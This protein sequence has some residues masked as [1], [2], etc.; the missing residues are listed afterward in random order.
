[1]KKLT[2]KNFILKAQ[3]VHS[4]KYNYDF[5]I[6]GHAKLKVK[7][8]CPQHGIFKMTPNNHLYGKQGCPLCGDE[9]TRT[10]L[11][12]FIQRC[13]QK[14]NNKYN[15]SNVK[16]LGGRKKVEIICP[17]HGIFSQ[18]PD[19]HMNTGTGCPK[20]TY[21][22]YVGGYS[23]E[24]FEVNNHFKSVSAILYLVKFHKDNENFY[25]IGITTQPLYKR[26]SG[27]DYDITPVATKPTTLFEA[28][29]LEQRLFDKL[30][31][32]KHTPSTK[33]KG[34]TECFQLNENV[35]REFLGVME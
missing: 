31:T 29:Q 4:N 3:Q 27:Y 9:A 26:F 20:C 32:Y 33:F 1:M 15:Y 25:K 17:E 2:T 30:T 21:D 14:H 24:F 6:Y 10:P 13:N 19:Q 28:F 35:T 7:I 22:N 23:K 16:L 5:V 8:R 12:D 18:T 11:E 34:W